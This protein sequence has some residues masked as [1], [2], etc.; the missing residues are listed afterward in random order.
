[1]NVQLQQKGR[2]TA[3][4]LAAVLLHA[5]ILLIPIVQEVMPEP[6]VSSR[7]R[8]QISDTNRQ[9]ESETPDSVPPSELPVEEQ[10]PIVPKKPVELAELPASPPQPVIPELSQEPVVEPVVEQDIS[11]RILS[12]QFDFQRVEPLFGAHKAEVGDQPDFYFRDRPG[13]DDAL[14]EPSL[15]LPFRDTRVY[16]VNSY[17]AGIGGGVE[18]FFDKVTVP[19][20]WTTKNNTRIHCAWV[21]IISGC[22]WGHVSLFKNKAKRRKPDSEDQY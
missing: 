16:L 15:Q 9:E 22:S 21:L 18:R 3:I 20:G 1:M 5:L 2:F 10:S 11:G 4:L 14:N 7:I 17:S 19:F 8:L 6:K 13:L 12:S